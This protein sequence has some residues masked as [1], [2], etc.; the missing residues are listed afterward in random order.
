MLSFLQLFIHK[1]C[2]ISTFFEPEM[3]FKKHFK[4]WNE[5]SKK[6]SLLLSR[7]LSPTISSVLRFLSDILTLLEYLVGQHERVV[8]LVA[9]NLAFWHR[10]GSS[11]AAQ[12]C[13][14]GC[15]FWRM[16]SVCCTV[17]I[18]GGRL[19]D[20]G[21]GEVQIRERLGFRDWVVREC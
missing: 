17:A 5:R 19:V 14:W 21:Q 20:L 15:W 7:L 9:H 10:F 12:H 1:P 18:R 16:V 11:A 4:A 3:I 8:R 6:D 2:L 13:G